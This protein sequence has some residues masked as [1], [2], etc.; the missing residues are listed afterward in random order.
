MTIPLDPRRGAGRVLGGSQYADRDGLQY[1]VV[2]IGLRILSA[3]D[4]PQIGRDQPQR[5]TLT[6]AR[7]PEDAGLAGRAVYR[8]EVFDQRLPFTQSLLASFQLDHADIDRARA[9][10]DTLAAGIAGG[11]VDVETADLA[12]IAAMLDPHPPT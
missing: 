10:L 5:V 12:G 2:A 7:R 6:T 3:A 8:V 11:A 4:T 1:R 9:L